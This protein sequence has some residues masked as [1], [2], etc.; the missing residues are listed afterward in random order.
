MDYETMDWEAEAVRVAWA[1]DV[2]TECKFRQKVKRFGEWRILLSCGRNDVTIRDDLRLYVT[3]KP[4][5][6]WFK[7]EDKT[8][9]LSWT[10]VTLD[11]NGR[12]VD[13]GTT[14]EFSDRMV[15]GLCR[16][17]LLTPEIDAAL[18]SGAT[19]HEKLEWALE[20]VERNGL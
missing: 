10:W 7:L 18:E 11:M 16:L 2:K 20:F 17:G 15:K 6:M 9:S 1:F 5:S 4:Q 19:A 13:A 14:H 3:Y 12:M 8:T